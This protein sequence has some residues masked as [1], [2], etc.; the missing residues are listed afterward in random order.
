M[1]APQIK[2][3][4]DTDNP[5]IECNIE[6]VAHLVSSGSNINFY[7]D[8]NKKRLEEELNKSLETRIGNY[9]DKTINEFETD[10][11]R[12]RKICKTQLFNLAR[13]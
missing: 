13:F 6:L 4:T 5:K 2:V 8:D 1:K 9:L 10:I 11:A 7:E 12:I 3:S